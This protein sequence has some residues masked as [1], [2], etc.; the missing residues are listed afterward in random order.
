MKKVSV[1]IPCYNEEAT[2]VEL[3]SRVENADFGD[4]QKEIIVV[5]DGSS[6]GTR[7]LLNDYKDKPEYRVIFHEKNKGK[8]GVERTAIEVASGDYLVIQDADLEYNPIEIKKL[9]DHVDNTGAHVVFGSRNLDGAWKR[10]YNGFFYIS[11]G[12]W[13]S[14][15]VINVLYGLKLTDA[16]TCY[17]LFSKEVSKK[18]KFIGNGFEA[19]YIFIGEVAVSGYD[20]DEVLI[21]HE[22][23]TVEEGKKIRY[24]DG[25]KS[26]HLII[27]H[28]LSNLNKKKRVLDEKGKKR[29]RKVMEAV[30]CPEC[31]GQLKESGESLTCE[32]HGKYGKSPQGVPLLVDNGVYLEHEQEHLTG[33]N[34]LKS[35]F[36]QFPRFY[37]YF[38]WGVF[39]PVLRVFNGPKKI[40]SF[41]DRESLILDI[42]SGPQRVDDDIISLDIFPFQGVDIAADATNLPFKDSS[43][44]GLINES[45]L[46]HVEKPQK[47]TAE[48]MR[49]V[50]PGGYIYTSVPFIHPFHASP[51]DYNR[52]TT[53]GLRALFKDMDEVEMGVRSGPWSAFLIFMAYWLGSIFS[54]GS[55]K[56]APFIAHM[57]MLILGPLK[58]LDYVFA[59]IP[60]A[61]V[62][63]AHVYIIVKK[64]TS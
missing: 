11:I 43:I 13:F 64:P 16:W 33:I 2:I 4:W 47:V 54:F 53:S 3:L 46:E 38:I 20:I 10:A 26:L 51:D 12:V 52:W 7:G 17:K 40:F 34:W 6:D 61:D 60:G 36:K 63:S 30:V 39:C 15:K 56:K 45:I 57:F 37:Y 31:Y 9:L 50:K 14:T 18:A 5:D 42:G 62:V 32:I 8:G 19:D 41:L 58:V 25:L 21:S 28:R 24:A 48:M 49:V 23:R 35:F 55:R 59:L 22:P 27:K 44:D 29:Q 1:I